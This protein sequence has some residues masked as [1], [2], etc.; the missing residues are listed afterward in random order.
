MGWRSFRRDLLRRAGYRRVESRKKCLDPMEAEQRLLA[1]RRVEV[2]FD[3]GA[4]VGQTAVKY[5]ASFPTARVYSFEPFP[6]AFRALVERCRGDALVEPLQ[7]AVAA[8]V[9][10]ATFHVNR[11]NFNHSLLA[12]HADGARW[13]LVDHVGTIEVPR[14]TVD[15]FRAERGLERIDLLKVDAEGSDLD[16][17]RGAAGSLADHR[18]DAVYVEV[19]FVPV[20]EGQ[21]TFHAM[22]ALMDEHGYGLFDLFEHRYD[23]SGR[24]KL[25]NALF[26][27]PHV[28]ERC[29]AGSGG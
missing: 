20:F 21:G 13:A 19:L 12:A 15:A 17:L 3:V 7:M 6:D 4:N 5:R 1:G 11:H 24:L 26:A 2:I 29:A 8:E 10:T 16:V 22:C 18:V 27:A 14:T 28:L 25:A 9:G 23:E